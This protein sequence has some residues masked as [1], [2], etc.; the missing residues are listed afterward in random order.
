VNIHIS[1]SHSSAIN[2]HP[3]DGAHSVWV[4]LGAVGI[5]MTPDEARDLAGKL[6]AVADAPMQEQ[7]A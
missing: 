3:H 6:L 5:F 7:A 1:A 4:M 2:V